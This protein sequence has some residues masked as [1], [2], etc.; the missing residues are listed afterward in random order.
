MDGKGIQHV[1][2]LVD[3]YGADLYDLAPEGLLHAVVIKGI[4][5]VADVPFQI[6]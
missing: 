6:K 5:L 2:V 3:L 1:G 4:R